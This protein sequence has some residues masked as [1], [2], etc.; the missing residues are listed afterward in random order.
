M[1]APGRPVALV[2]GAGSG[3]G[4]ATA[5]QLAADGW[6][7]A[8]VGRRAEALEAVA[9]HASAAGATAHVVPGD[10]AD[11]DVPAAVV[12]EAARRAGRLDGLVLNAG[13]VYHQPL[14]AWSTAQFDEH[15]AVNVR[16]PFFAVQAALPWLRR[17]PRPA[18]VTVSSSSA[19][20]L[21]PTQCVYGMSKAA[22]EYVTRSLAAELA[23]EG[24]R[25]NAVAPGPIDTPIHETWAD[26]LDEARRWL[27]DQVPLGRIGAAEEVA[28][29]IGRLLSPSAAFMTG[30][31]LPIDGGQTLDHR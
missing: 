23:A 17:A 19:T 11:P 3:I 10:L 8:L 27:A 25:V 4:A 9:E 29:W 13:V 26:D 14:D 7:V 28:S 18:V 6:D 15:V 1:A 20:L 16:A 24:I 22:L 12:V 2:T 30:V 21:R 31:V 5:V